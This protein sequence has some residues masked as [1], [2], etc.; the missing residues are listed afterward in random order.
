MQAGGQGFESPHLH[1]IEK[2][3]ERC[4]QSEIANKLKICYADFGK[5]YLEN[6]IQRDNYK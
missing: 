5:L 3:I 4:K 6:F 2:S 1:S